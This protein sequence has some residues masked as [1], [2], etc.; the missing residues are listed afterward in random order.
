M[1]QLR[2]PNVLRSE[3]RENENGVGE[4]VL[5]LVCCR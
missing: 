5:V 1:W 3:E 4:P 2:V